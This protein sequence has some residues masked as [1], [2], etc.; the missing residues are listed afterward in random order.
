MIT[1]EVCGMKVQMKCPKLFTLVEFAFPPETFW[2]TPD[3]G[4][5]SYPMSFNFILLT[6]PFQQK[7]LKRKGIAG[8]PKSF[9]IDSTTV[10][11]KSIH[12]P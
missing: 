3:L 8:V 2:K 10:Y 12:L 5:M 7:P 11:Q 4:F 9:L 6:G 1:S